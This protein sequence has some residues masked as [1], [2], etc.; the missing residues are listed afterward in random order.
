MGVA[1]FTLSTSYNTKKSS[2]HIPIMANV[3]LK[4]PGDVNMPAPLHP[5]PKYPEIWLPNFNP[6]EGTQA[7]EHLHNFMLAINLKEVSEE[8]CVCRLFPYTFLG[9]VGS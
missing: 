8:Y 2:S 5:L 4:N 1:P 6:D 7:E 9:S 3:P